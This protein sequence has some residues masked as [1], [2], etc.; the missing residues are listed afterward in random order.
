M[1]YVLEVVTVEIARL[2]DDTA[3]ITFHRHGEELG[4]HTRET[5]ATNVVNPVDI[6]V[7][8]T[9]ALTAWAGRG[10]LGLLRYTEWFRMDSQFAHGRASVRD[11]ALFDPPAG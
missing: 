9:E 3:V 6:V 7:I 8:V 4:R 2:S 10:V 1:G 11:P 5:I